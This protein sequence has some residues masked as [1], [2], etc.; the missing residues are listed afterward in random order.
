MPERYSTLFHPLFSAFNNAVL[1]LSS[2]CMKFGNDVL[3]EKYAGRINIRQWESIFMVFLLFFYSIQVYR[4]QLISR[5]KDCIKIL[6]IPIVYFIISRLKSRFYYIENI[7]S[8]S[9]HRS[10]RQ[11]ALKYRSISLVL[12]FLF[13]WPLEISLQRIDVDNFNYLPFFEKKTV[14]ELRTTTSLPLIT[15]Y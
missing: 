5:K 8:S 6:S 3:Y 2:K 11:L 4:K 15:S 10:L 7:I 12:L 1:P 9:L 13:V 14:S